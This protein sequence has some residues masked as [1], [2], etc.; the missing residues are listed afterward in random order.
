ML[1]TYKMVIA[2]FLVDINDRNSHLFEITLLL[3][4]MN[5]NVAFGMFFPTL[6]N[7]EVNVNNQ[8]LL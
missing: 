2:L 5:M 7:V 1:E 8:E 6:S 3:A 4:D